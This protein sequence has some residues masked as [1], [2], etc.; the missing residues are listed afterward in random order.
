MTLVKYYFDFFKHNHEEI[1]SR[2]LL[3][4]G[5]DPGNDKAIVNADQFSRFDQLSRDMVQE[6]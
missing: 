2:L 6:Q 4:L 1:V 3:V 5:L